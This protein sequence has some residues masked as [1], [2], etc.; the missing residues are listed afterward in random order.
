MMRPLDKKPQTPEAPSPA[1]P[2]TD[3]QADLPEE[4]IR[5][6]LQLVNPEL[7]K[8][9]YE[10]AKAQLAAEMARHTRLDAKATSLVSS[11]GISL[12]L[13]MSIA[14]LIAN[15]TISVPWWLWI[16]LTVA[17]LSGVLAVGFG[18]FALMVKNGFARVSDRN[19]FDKHTL[20]FANAPTGCDDLT[21]RKDKHAYGAA[22]YRQYMTA[23]LWEVGVKEHRQLNNKAR[24]V[25]DGQVLFMIFL[26]VLVV[27]VAT[28]F[29]MTSTRDAGAPAQA[30]A[31]QGAIR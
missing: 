1:R 9:L 5:A 14:T 8:E 3:D 16:M 20:A 31:A 13:G 12:T 2:K 30:P 11:A 25:R 6:R 27:C 24:Q 15:R 19:V 10:L 18:I 4:E 28:E 23:H 17:G 29:V 21:D 7:T 22:A 26:A